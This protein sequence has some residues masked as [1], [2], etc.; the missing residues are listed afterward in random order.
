MPQR[1]ELELLLEQK[2]NLEYLLTIVPLNDTSCKTYESMLDVINA[3]IAALS[4]DSNC[5]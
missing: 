4:S 3:R 1:D 2:V 5:N